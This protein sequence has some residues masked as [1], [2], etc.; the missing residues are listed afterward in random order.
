MKDSIIRVIYSEKDQTARIDCPF[1][2]EHWVFPFT[3]RETFGRPH[4]SPGP[5][6]ALHLYGCASEPRICRNFDPLNPPEI[7]E[8]TDTA[9][10]LR[11]EK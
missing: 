1:C 7:M 8:L 6:I 5:L 11:F 9:A 2:G 10:A 4:P 3:A